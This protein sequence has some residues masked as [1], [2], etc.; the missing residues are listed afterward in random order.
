MC[1]IANDE[2]LVVGSV[3]HQAHAVSSGATWVQDGGVVDT[4]VYLVADD[5]V[6]P[7]RLGLL[8]VDVVDVAM[9]WVRDL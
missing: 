7:L 4:D 9:G 6:Q 5:L 3:A 2:T 8:L 1:K